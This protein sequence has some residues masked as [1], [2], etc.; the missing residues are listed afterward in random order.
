VRTMYRL[1]V[2][3]MIATG[4]VISSAAAIFSG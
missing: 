2:K 4:S 1:N 3:K